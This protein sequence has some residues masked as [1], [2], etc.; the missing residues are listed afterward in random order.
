MKQVISI[1]KSKFCRRKKLNMY[2]ILH[3]FLSSLIFKYHIIF[4]IIHNRDIYFSLC[5][6][7]ILNIGLSSSEN[8]NCTIIILLYFVLKTTNQTFS[9]MVETFY[10]SMNL[11]K[12][13]YEQLYY[14]RCIMWSKSYISN[15]SFKNITY[16]CFLNLFDNYHFYFPFVLVHRGAT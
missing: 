12:C 9:K 13:L 4:A 1:K 11:R 15:K 3:K 14:G 2:Y 8:L 5:W 16:Q 6:N 10:C 7:Q